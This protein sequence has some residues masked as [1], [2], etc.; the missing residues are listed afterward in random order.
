MQPTP[1]PSS[2]NRVDS[3]SGAP[4][5]VPSSTEAAQQTAAGLARRGLAM[6]RHWLATSSTTEK[7]VAGG[8][9]L[10][11]LAMG[12]DWYDIIKIN[13]WSQATQ[14]VTYGGVNQT[15]DP[16]MGPHGMGWISVLAMLTALAVIAPASLWRNRV[17]WR[18][19]LADATMLMVLGAVEF[20]ALLVYSMTIRVS[21]I[22]DFQGISYDEWVQPGG[23]F[24]LVALGVLLTV[25]G[26]WRLRRNQRRAAAAPVPTT[27]G[28]S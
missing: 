11:V 10:I 16:I 15:T 28:D 24:Y 19:P 26:G 27:P 2:D 23:G 12:T 13:T 7:L 21:S 5:A 22:P 8:S 1:T 4:S 9:A 20:L 14:Y 6:V 18:P 25:I 3:A 17:T